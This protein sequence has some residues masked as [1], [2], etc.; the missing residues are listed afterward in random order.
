VYHIPIS[1]TMIG[2]KGNGVAVLIDQ[3]IHDY[4]T[5]WH[6]SEQI[7]AIW[8]KCAGQ[9]F[10]VPGN[11]ALGA[12]YLN[13]KT[14]KRSNSDITES[15]EHFFD[16]ATSASLSFTNV[17][18][19]GDFNAHIGDLSEFTDEH[20]DIHDDFKCLQHARL[21][22]CKSVNRAGK[23]LLDI[24]AAGPY[25]LTTGRGKGDSGQAT[26]VG[27]HGRHRSRP[28]HILM[29]PKFYHNLLSTAIQPS[30]ERITDHCSITAC[31][32]VRLV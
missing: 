20:Y 17:L 3:G 23:L 9:V 18:M 12:V 10:N 29:T 31:F 19:M 24:A 6:V 2:G 28:D 15:F 4:V 8:L 26:F 32:K 5:V 27:Y 16:E 7:Q 13:P 30:N 25:M 21:T 11:V 14:E 22:C 1:S